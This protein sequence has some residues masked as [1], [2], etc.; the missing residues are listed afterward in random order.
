MWYFTNAEQIV[1]VFKPNK[2]KFY[3]ISLL[4][5]VLIFIPIILFYPFSLKP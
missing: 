3:A 2:A 4:F 5:S 1:E